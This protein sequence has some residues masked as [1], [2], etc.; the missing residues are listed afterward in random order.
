VTSIDTGCGA[1]D[2]SATVI[3]AAGVAPYTIEWSTGAT[4]ETINDLSAGDYLV[5]VTDSEGCFTTCVATI[6][7]STNPVCTV[8]GT[9]T[10]CGEVNGSATATIENG[11]GPYTY[12]WSNGESSETITDLGAGT[13]DVTVTDAAGCF[14]SCSITILESENP[15]CTV[16]GIDTG[17]LGNTGEATATATGGV[18]PYSY[19]WSNGGSEQTITGLAAGVYEVTVSDASSCTTTCSI[20]IGNTEL[21]TC[22]IEGTNAEC[23]QANGSATA[24]VVGGTAPFVY[25][26]GHGPSGQTV[27]G[28]TPGVYELVVRDA[29]GCFT[30]CEVL[31]EGNEGLACSILGTNAGCGSQDGSAIVTVTG[32]EAPFTYAWS[33]NATGAELVDLAAG[34]YMVTT[35]DAAGCSTTCEVAIQEE[36]CAID[37][38]LIKTVSD[39]E[40]VVGETVTFTLSLTNNGPD[41]ATG[42]EVTDYI[43]SGYTSPI[44]ISDNGSLSAN[45][46]TWSGMTLANGETIALTFDV[47]VEYEGE[48]MNTAQVTAA[49]QQDSDSVPGNDDGDQSEDDEDSASTGPVAYGSIGNYVWHDVN[50]D[51]IQEANE[52][53]IQ[54]ISVNLLDAAGEIVATVVTDADGFYEFTEVVPGSY[55]VEVVLDSDYKPTQQDMG[56]ST[57][58]E[59][60]SDISQFNGQSPLIVLGPNEVVSNVD[61]GLYLPAT[62][63]NQLWID[64][65]GSVENEFKAGDAP[66]VEVEVHLYDANSGQRVKTVISNENGTYFFVDIV[67]GDYFVQFDIPGGYEFV[68][69]GNGANSVVDSDADPETGRTSVFTLLSGDLNLTIFRWLVR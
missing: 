41:D 57:S 30:T 12:S 2:G 25:K 28:L 63:G 31:I 14:T 42:V 60:D 52:T 47:T 33:N 38:A 8:E 59:V 11:V 4:T 7:G 66:L 24:T 23:G 16:E 19:N 48:F 50:Y 68:E 22:T 5:T 53:G 13:Y 62:V 43:P 37:L 15:T 34:I 17:C 26:W 46:V 1:D 32:G 27:D 35:T 55:K 40:P 18:G 10:T 44:N 9:D 29:K 65:P 58:E 69:Q 6:I 21:P 20:E 54:G 36:V 3:P 56:G 39:Q 51:G 61:A 64:V 49:D 67:P 45:N